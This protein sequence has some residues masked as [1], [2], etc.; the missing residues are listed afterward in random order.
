MIKKKRNQE[1]RDR[2]DRVKYATLLFVG[3]YTILTYCS[4]QVAQDTENRQLRSYLGPVSAGI[5]QPVIGGPLRVHI[6]VKNFGLTPAYRHHM[7]SLQQVVPKV[8]DSAYSLDDYRIQP[9]G[10]EVTIYPRS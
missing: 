4:L 9:H 5:E 6:E 10:N 8:N 1:R 2:N 3:A 7:K